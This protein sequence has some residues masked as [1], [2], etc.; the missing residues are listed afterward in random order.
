MADPSEYWKLDFLCGSFQDLAYPIRIKKIV[1]GATQ[2]QRTKDEPIEL[3]SVY[4]LSSL[5][6]VL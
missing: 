5:E 3:S 1:S 6:N 2:R 4:R